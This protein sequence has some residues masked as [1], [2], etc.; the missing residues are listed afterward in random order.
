MR[1]DFGEVR[2]NV[3]AYAEKT[4]QLLWSFE[5]TA[6]QPY[7]YVNARFA[8]FGDL[9]RSLKRALS[10]KGE[11]GEVLHFHT[12]SPGSGLR[13]DEHGELVDDL[14][15]LKYDEATGEVDM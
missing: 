14:N 10:I 9:Q 12:L 15:I 6:I 3:S 7:D 11:M 1:L 2:Y 5:Y 4:N 8:P 13:Y